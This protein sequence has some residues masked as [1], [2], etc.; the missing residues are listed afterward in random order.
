[1]S[2]SN[3]L[4]TCL[5]NVSLRIMLLVRTHTGYVCFTPYA[6]LPF[7]P[8]TI[9]NEKTCQAKSSQATLSQAKLNQNHKHNHNHDH[10]KKQNQAQPQAKTITRLDSASAHSCLS[11]AP[12]ALRNTTRF[13]CDCGSC[14]SC[15]NRSCCSCC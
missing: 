11:S 6:N 8:K 3:I 9:T 13:S 14:C 10:G 15:C 7:F 4:N 12:H 1:M 2:T 5:D